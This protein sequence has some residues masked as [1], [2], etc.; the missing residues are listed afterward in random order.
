MLDGIPCSACGAV[1]RIPDHLAGR[2]EEVNCPACGAVIQGGKPGAGPRPAGDRGWS[3]LWKG[4]ILVLS[5]ISAFAVGILYFAFAAPSP[6]V[7]KTPA[8]APAERPAPSETAAVS[9]LP[10]RSAA[11][12]AET[13]PVGTAPTPRNTPKT[14]PPASAVNPPGSTGGQS[15]AKTAT[16]S[17]TAPAKE[18]GDASA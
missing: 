16:L 6:D 1:H 7:S 14:S 15:G 10:P 4:V 3:K 13:S 9:A 8:P 17:P 5:G 11:E 18:S 12:I 2:G